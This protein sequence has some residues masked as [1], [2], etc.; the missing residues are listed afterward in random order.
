M[1]ETFENA[2]LSLA[3]HEMSGIVESDYGY[4]I[5]LRLPLDPDSAVDYA[6][7]S[8]PV[9]LRYAVAGSM[10]EANVDSWLEE[11]EVV[12]EDAFRNLELSELYEWRF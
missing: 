9:S 12:Y 7:S 1:L 3:E 2:V 4:H 8:E 5:I 11:A 6:D 10:F